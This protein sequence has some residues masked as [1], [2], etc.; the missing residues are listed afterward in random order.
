[1]PY[2][3]NFFGTCKYHLINYL[4]KSKS[5]VYFPLT[6]KTYVCLSKTMAKILADTFFLV[7]VS[8]LRFSV[9]TC[10][11]ENWIRAIF[12][13]K[14]IGTCSLMV[15]S[16]PPK[17]PYATRN[18]PQAKY[19]LTYLVSLHY[20]ANMFVAKIIHS[21]KIFCQFS[22]KISTTPQGKTK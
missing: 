19:C 20:F 4:W 14:E 3:V 22:N 7:F 16:V 15:C 5:T 18:I 21:L 17:T 2:R 8:Y 11:F 10:F 9:H 13:T 1:M 12:S 6:H